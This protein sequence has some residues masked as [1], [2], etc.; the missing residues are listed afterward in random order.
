MVID[1]AGHRL[2]AFVEGP[3]RC[4]DECRSGQDAK[5][6][7]VGLENQ[8]A[9]IMIKQLRPQKNTEVKFNNRFIVSI[10]TEEPY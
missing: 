7:E 3:A 9:T 6:I 2:D 5:S 4:S 10:W 8:N 1:P